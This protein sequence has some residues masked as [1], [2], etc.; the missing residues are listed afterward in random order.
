VVVEEF[1]GAEGALDHAASLA[2]EDTELVLVRFVKP[3]LNSRPQTDLRE[4]AEHSL[5]RVRAKFDGRMRREVIEASSMAAGLRDVVA[6]EHPNLVVIAQHTE[7]G[8]VEPKDGATDDFSGL[9]VKVVRV[10]TQPG[11]IQ[12]AYG[13]SAQTGFG[14]GGGMGT[15][16]APGDVVNRSPKT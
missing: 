9:P 14:E 1:P 16:A 4:D 3:P 13:D 12:D 11:R 6:R 10:P 2:S 7:A 8:T 5:E 15:A